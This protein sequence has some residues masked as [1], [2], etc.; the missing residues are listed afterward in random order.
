MQETRRLRM[1]S[2]IRE[3]LSTLILREIKDPR[4]PAVTITGVQV[5][6]DGGE[7]T[8]SVAILGGA[9]GGHDGAPPLSEKAAALRMKDCIAGLT[10]AGGFLKRQLARS[11]NTKL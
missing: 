4:V 9:Q 3:E 8:I 11:L 10:S 6:P 5:T 2:V 1:E 7:A